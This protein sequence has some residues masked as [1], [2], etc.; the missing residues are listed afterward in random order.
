MGLVL[1]WLVL[2]VVEGTVVRGT[3]AVVIPVLG[4]RSTKGESSADLTVR[5]TEAANEVPLTEAVIVVLPVLVAVTN[6]VVLTLATSGWLDDQLKMLAICEICWPLAS[7]AITIGLNMAVRR[8]P[9]VTVLWLGN[10]KT[11]AGMAM[12][13]EVAGMSVSEERV[14][15]V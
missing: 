1:V 10:I 11:R 7:I 9:K 15:I 3:V 4:V 14:E 6:P 5:K 8:V 12:F 13:S 2:G